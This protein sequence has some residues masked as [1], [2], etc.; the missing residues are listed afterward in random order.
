MAD[1]LDVV[2]ITEAAESELDEFDDCIDSALSEI[3]AV[4]FIEV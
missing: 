3:N 4:T 2:A 1:P